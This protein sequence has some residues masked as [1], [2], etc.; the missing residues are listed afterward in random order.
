MPR[1]WCDSCQDYHDVDEDEEEEIATM[2][3]SNTE[4]S[5]LLRERQAAVPQEHGNALYM[6]TASA[7]VS[8]YRTPLSILQ[9]CGIEHYTI[10]RN[11][12]TPNN[13]YGWH[14]SI[15]GSDVLIFA[16]PPQS[17]QN[18]QNILRNFAQLHPSFADDAWCVNREA[19]VI[20]PFPYAQQWVP[21][22]SPRAGSTTRL[23]VTSEKRTNCF[24]CA[25]VESVAE[26]QA[27]SS[28]LRTMYAHPMPFDQAHEIC[29]EFM[30]SLEI[31]G[32]DAAAN[33]STIKDV[34]EPIPTACGNCGQC[35]HRRGS[36]ENLPK[37]FDKVG[38]EIEG[39]FLNL[40]AVQTRSEGVLLGGY[41]DGSVYSS[42]D[43][44]ATPWEFQTK[45]GSLRSA[46]QQLV[47]FYP[48][49]TDSSAGMHVHV[50]FDAVDI[51]MLNDPA[52]F[53]Y[54]K[55]RWEAWGAKMQLH[56]RSQFFRRLQ[57]RNDFCQPAGDRP[58]TINRMDRY[59]QLNFSAFSE[60]GTVECRLL[61]MFKRASLGV[62]AVQELVNIYETYLADPATH[63]HAGF[64]SIAAFEAPNIKP[65]V[66]TP[67]ALDMPVIYAH[68]SKR[69]MELSEVL[70]P[71]PDHVRI[72]VAVNQPITLESLAR[73]VRARQ[74]R[75]A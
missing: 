62:A 57:G 75:A 5:A 21:A 23:R 32:E 68:S 42:P 13:A 7:V 9:N 20:L 51:T 48:D 28:G 71:K 55:A 63:G 19:G 40:S 8:Q 38:I 10:E 54:F 59:A 58:Y 18:A 64:D 17:A 24:H 72:A 15:S 49:E 61:P 16:T 2:P 56:P 47:D 66:L 11:S 31:L 26:A 12:Y 44:D 3:H 73:V 25:W 50:S 41:Q 70:P 37:A 52:F 35:G 22:V 46:C 74:N 60:H 6:Y 53:R 4:S 33:T 14:L 39:R 36:C 30:P 45:P 34:T 65:E 29:D 1:E 43:S 67:Q 27:R 69:E